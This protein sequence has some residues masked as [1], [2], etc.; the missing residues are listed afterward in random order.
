MRPVFLSLYVR[1]YY[2]LKFPEERNKTTYLTQKWT[3]LGQHIAYFLHSNTDT[4]I[5]TIL[6]DLKTVA[7]YSV[8]NMIISHMQSLAVSFSSGMEA[9]FGDML[10]R[11]EKEELHHTFQAYETIL[12]VVSIILFSVAA[13]LIIPFIR[14]YTDGITDADYV[15]PLFALFM[16]LTALSY[17]VRLPYHSLVIAAGHFKRTRVAAY[18]EA[19]LN[20]ALSVILV[21]RFNL[22]GV[23]M[24]TLI[25]TWFRFIYYVFYLSKNIFNR[26]I[27][28][29]VKRFMINA[30]AFVCNCVVGYA[31]ASCFVFE[32]YLEWAFCGAVLV[33]IIGIITLGINIVF[34]KKD[35]FLLLNKIKR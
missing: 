3:G 16:I 21:F 10:A 25:A 13:V 9:V 14:L 35:C 22:I 8:Y 30:G 5:L 24:A 27:E 20:I 12:S 2:S 7:I 34:F 18:G 33:A 19:I 29:F 1:K 15:R 6:V 17:C 4:A 31:V 32:N 26:S 11:N 23:A 28:L